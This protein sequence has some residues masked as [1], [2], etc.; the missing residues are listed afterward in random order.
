MSG[1]R[2]TLAAAHRNDWAFVLAATVRRTGDL[3]LAEEC[4]QEAYLA[5]LTAWQSGVPDNPAAWLSVTA[6]NKAL[7]RL[8]RDENL[9]RRLPLLAVA[10]DSDANPEHDL[11]PDDR[12][13]L[14]FTCCHPALSLEARVALT[15]RM[16]GGLSTAEVARACLVTTSTMAARLTR[17]KKKIAAAEIPYRIPTAEDLPERIDGVLTVIELIIATGHTAPLGTSLVR[18][19]TLGRG[20][21]IARMLISVLPDEPQARA[22]VAIGL[23]ARARAAA[24]I[25]ADGNLVTLAEQ[26]RMLWDQAQIAEACS[27]TDMAAMTAPRAR[28]VL[29]AQIAE[30]HAT[31]TSAAATDWPRILEL[32]TT[33]LEVSPSPV[34][35]LN[36]AVAVAEVDGAQ[37]A[38]DGIETLRDDPAVAGYVYLPIVEAELLRRVG[39]TA[40]ADAAYGR[41]LALSGN[42][43]ERTHL[44]LRRASL[45][46]PHNDSNEG[47]R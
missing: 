6:R 25:S 15:L 18:V 2:E 39:R 45:A 26:D 21:D 3:D 35:A 12:L 10:A 20:I 14:I 4:V 22:L 13:R 37:A 47:A 1:L 44:Q 24:R 16:V 19:D 30:Q 34:V 28:L 38:L 7:D 17:A 41:A 42:D 40:D 43:T 33:L 23:F 9:R 11:F 27:L 8:R 5:A 36:R 29:H 31:A 32:Y 46:A